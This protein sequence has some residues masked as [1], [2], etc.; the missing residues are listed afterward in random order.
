[1]TAQKKFVNIGLVQEFLK[2]VGGEPAINV[3]TI[4]ERK[5]KRVTDEELAKKMRMKVTEIRTVLNRLHYRGIA[6]YKKTKNK[7]NG[8]YNY[9]WE[10]KKKRIIELI[11]ETQQ[12]RIEKLEAKQQFGENYSFFTCKQSCELLPFEIAAEYQFKC[13]KC[14]ETM[15]AYD[16]TKNLETINKEIDAL[17]NEVNKLKN[18][19]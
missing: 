11:L 17:K 1:M 2:K 10:I 5:G 6:C 13:P 19:K 8:W 16:Y 7:R 15:D 14:G 12:E 9:T 3:T 18:A 4:Y